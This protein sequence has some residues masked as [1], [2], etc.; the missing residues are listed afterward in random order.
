[1]PNTLIY[2]NTNI[3]ET[4]TDNE[5]NI[6][7][8]PKGLD[9]EI[10]NP[11]SSVS[12]V[13][14]TSSSDTANIFESPSKSKLNNFIVINQWKGEV[15]ACNSKEFDAIIIDLKEGGTK[16]E[17]TFSIDDVSEDDR[18]LIQEGAIFY[19]EIGYHVFRGTRMKASKLKFRRMPPLSRRKI[20]QLFDYANKMTAELKFD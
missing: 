3:Q 17:I 10:V 11:T 12:S 20:D 6:G 19:W 15:I 9:E 5:I 2:Q 13:N 14:K 4:D 7:Y 1:M 18:N 8:A 16:E